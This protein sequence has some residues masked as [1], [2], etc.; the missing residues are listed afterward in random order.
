[1]ERVKVEICQLDNLF[2]VNFVDR[3]THMVD[4]GSTLA[5]L[6]PNETQEGSWACIHNGKT[7]QPE[8][9]SE[10]EIRDGSQLIYAPIP[11]DLVTIGA[12][13]LDVLTY[14]AVSLAA[15][16]ITYQIIGTPEIDG[17]QDE[18]T[19][20]TFAN[21]RQNSG[22]G[23]PI[24]VVYGT[25]PVA[26]NVIE[27]DLRGNNPGSGN[28]YGSTMDILIGLCEGEIVS[29]DKITVNG[30]D[31]DTV[32][33]LG[34]YETRLGTN[35]QTALGTTGTTTVQ[36]V[37]LDLPAPSEV[38][39][40]L[41]YRLLGRNRTSIFDNTAWTNGTPAIGTS[42][43]GSNGLTGSATVYGAVA[44]SGQTQDHIDI[45]DIVEPSNL[46][47][48]S[49]NSSGFPDGDVTGTN[50]Q[51]QTTS[52]EIY[53]RSGT[54]T[55]NFVW[56][57]GEAVSYTTTEV[58]DR[59]RLNI[60]FPEGLYQSDGNGL[61]SRTVQFGVRY[62]NVAEVDQSN[63]PIEA[64]SVE[65]IVT[66]TAEHVGPWL[67]TY[68]L[69]FVAPGTL[70]DR[71]QYEI[72]IRHAS[73]DTDVDGYRMKLDSVVEIQNQEF[74]YPNTAL[75]YANLNSDQSLNGS[76]IPNIVA[77]IKGRKI[78][79]W[80]RVSTTTP[81]FV[82]DSPD[83]NTP[84]WIVYDLL[85][86]TRYGLGNW[87]D[88][89]KIDLQSFADW[90]DWCNE[91][92]ED[93]Q[94]GSE[95][96]CT[97]DGLFEAGASAWD[98]ILTVCTSARAT[99]YTVGETIKV[100]HERDRTPTQMF[101]MGNIQESSWTQSFTS[102][103]ERPTRVDVQFLNA[104]S[105][106]QVDVVGADDPDAT[107]ASLP[108]RTL[109]VDLR[110]VTRESQALREAR[111]RLNLDKLGQVVSWGADIDAVACEPGDLVEVSHDTC[112]WGESGRVLS[113]G[114]GADTVTLDRDLTLE[115]GVSYSILL[116]HSSDDSRDT[117]TITSSAGTY[118]S[119]ST[120]TVDSDWSTTVAKHDLYAVGP[121][122][123]QSKQVIITSIRTTGDLKRQIEGVVYDPSIHEDQVVTATSAF[124]SL[125][126]PNEP[127]GA[128]L[129]LTVT[130]LKTER[131]QAAVSW[132]YPEDVQI[133]SARI[134]RRSEGQKTYSQ[135]GAVEWP[136]ANVVIPFDVAGTLVS[137]EV[138]EIVVVPVSPTGS[139]LPPDNFLPVT[140]SPGGYVETPS[141]PGGAT[142]TQSDDLLRIE[143]SAP[144]N[145]RI[146][147]YEVRRGLN[148]TGS[149]P[150]G[151]S[152]D[153]FLVTSDWTPTL[154]SGLT[155]NYFV[156][157]ITPNGQYG[158][159]A[160]VSE[161]NTLSSWGDG[162]TYIYNV[163]GAS[164]NWSGTTL[165]NMQIAQ[166]SGTR[167]VQLI[168]PGTQGK[169]QSDTF[170]MSSNAKYKIGAICHAYL[171]DL[172]WETNKSAWNSR[173]NV[174]RTWNGY[175]DPSLWKSSVSL[176][177]RTRTTSSGSFTD[178]KPLT[179]RSTVLSFLEIELL[180]QIDP[181]DSSQ[182]V[183]IQELLLVTET[184]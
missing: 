144:T 71:G 177:F 146:S 164:Q 101:G 110:G 31:L 75:V 167:V 127:P 23:I 112:N 173:D 52:L 58:V 139:H 13:L 25:H 184:V 14:V 2:P 80:D 121:L 72:E 34:Q 172:T 133:G 57:G 176:F 183:E 100:K 49:T 26:G 104:A 29:I 1:M 45:R 40:G 85:T 150:V 4:V 47:S 175:A 171:E 74:T 61:H 91:L 92:V 160:T 51:G 142:L 21:L 145:Q 136:Q 37:N 83:Y 55:E 15:S 43:T 63:N 56:T 18:E 69:N 73:Q 140:F 182:N 158:K 113:A 67:Y 81:N 36:T 42:V 132:R 16:Y 170:T 46:D 123:T 17:F 76:S 95:K 70:P 27:L 137:S 48:T 151:F 114:T 153:P 86:N 108:Q 162:T 109:N 78:Q 125:L 54:P 96:R 41:I 50:S 169:L 143:W 12:F 124:R 38:S 19:T 116:R 130:E 107:T 3:S 102:R 163:K 32:T 122:N 168:T 166:I 79:K 39:T 65:D 60:L 111:F 6:A 59:T 157:S 105:N 106:Y 147:R 77:T 62:R 7:V 90:A 22:P 128:V 93:G 89:T 119:G 68:D 148:W 165:S 135:V 159:V 126:D 88:S 8:E 118:T 156:R 44:G 154:S 66:V 30:N 117:R 120:I 181:V 10:V 64:W 87:V 134:Y 53:F 115:A 180:V 152:V 131:T 24:K 33:S 11:E 174:G 149:I 35:T 84:A 20:Y 179:S 97:W 82:D 9:W 141:A 94:G 28:P 178:W 98:A 99:L 103:L 129:D 161:T 5:H 138:Y 155:E